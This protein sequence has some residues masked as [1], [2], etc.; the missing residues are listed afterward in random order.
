MRLILAVLLLAFLGAVGVFA[1]Q[2]TQ[3][4][5]VRFLNRSVTAPLAL[6]AVGIYLLGM[7][8]GWNVVSFVRRSIHRVTTEPRRPR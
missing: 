4:V 7:V 1:A 3:D 2:N 8:S 6:L 5:T